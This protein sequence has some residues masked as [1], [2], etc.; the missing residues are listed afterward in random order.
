M[1]NQGNLGGAW[2]SGFLTGLMGSEEPKLG[3]TG[4][5]G[6][7]SCFQLQDSQTHPCFPGAKVPCREQ[8]RPPT[9][10]KEG[11]GRGERQKH[12]LKLP[13]EEW[14]VAYTET[15]EGSHCAGTWSQQWVTFQGGRFRS[16]GPSRLLSA[17]N[18]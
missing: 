12:C 11:R 14:H 5:N 15:S 2:E 13:T 8:P 17:I 1:L 9:P 10:D 6:L 18:L 7:Y 4:Q 16:K 3:T